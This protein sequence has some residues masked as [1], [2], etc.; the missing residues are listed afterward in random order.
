MNSSI[1]LAVALSL[2]LGCTNLMAT[3]TLTNAP[4]LEI[5]PITCIVRQL[6][7]LCKMTVKV[8]WQAPH[9][10]DACLY[11]EETKM[12]CW[13]GKKSVVEK[14]D[15]SLQKNMTF[16]LINSEQVVLAQQVIKVNAAMSSQ[17]RRRL[18]TDWS[19]F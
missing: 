9:P 6:G 19:I 13:H 18:K 1:Q 10:I 3:G 11:Q 2:L 15:I 4:N 17:Y 16:R 14:L 5:K 7:E 12:Q 8:N